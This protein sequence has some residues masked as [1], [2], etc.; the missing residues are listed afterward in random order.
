MNMPESK[1][2]DFYTVP[3]EGQ[4]TQEARSA[5]L[6]AFNPHGVLNPVFIIQTWKDEILNLQRLARHLGPD[7]PIFSVNPPRGETRE[8]FPRRDSVWSDYAL[9]RLDRLGHNG[10]WRIGGWSF[11]GTLCLRIAQHLMDR[12]ET[13]ETVILYDSLYPGLSRSSRHNRKSNPI[14]RVASTINDYYDRP[15]EAREKARRKMISG[16]KRRLTLGEGKWASSRSKRMT[17]LH[18]AIHVAYLN[19]QGFEFSAPVDLLWT[20]QTMKETRDLTLGWRSLV[21]GPFSSQ[22][23]AERH[24]EMWDEPDIQ[25]VAD[26]T[27]SILNRS[28]NK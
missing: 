2:A 21:R 20:D 28:S 3:V 18:R 16:W 26:A 23:V 15:A 19:Y 22:R 1:M 13:V 6:I 25:Q 4:I 12:G 24:V 7:Q 5:D 9:E 27:R 14:H 17:L 10:P 8:D 11:G